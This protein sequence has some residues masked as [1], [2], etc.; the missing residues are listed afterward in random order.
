VSETDCR[1]EDGQARHD[2]FER[3]FCGVAKRNFAEVSV[4]A[5]KF[6]GRLWLEYFVEY[7]HLTAAGRWFRGEI[8]REAAERVK[9][10]DAAPM[11]GDMKRYWRGG[12][13]FGGVA[14]LTTG[15]LDMW[16]L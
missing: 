1:C 5:C 9:P 8:T 14:A 10:D 15:P 13:A 4:L 6:C 2:V 3:R 12:S 7:E 11:F 16:L